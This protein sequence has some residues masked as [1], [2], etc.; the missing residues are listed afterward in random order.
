MIGADAHSR[1]E[2]DLDLISRLI[3]EL[4]QSPSMQ[5]LF[6]VLVVVARL[7]LDRWERKRE[8]AKHE[9]RRRPQDG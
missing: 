2:G 6:F 7:A 1:M 4:D 8:R 3:T 9:R 5:A